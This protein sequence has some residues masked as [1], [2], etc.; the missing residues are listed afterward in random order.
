M[1][2][3]ELWQTLNAALQA[4]PLQRIE[5][6]TMP[7]A[8]TLQD[9]FLFKEYETAVALTNHID[10]LRDKL[11]SFF[12][13]FTGLAGAAISFLILD[14]NRNT[15]D[16]AS[17]PIFNSLAEPIIATL[18][19]V[20]FIGIVI[21]AIM[22]KLRAVQLEHFRIISNIRVY[23]FKSNYELWNV[24]QLS[25]KTLPKPRLWSGTYFWFLTIALISSAL[26]GAAAFFSIRVSAWRDGTPYMVGAVFFLVLLATHWLYFYTAT[27][28]PPQTYS[29]TN[30]PL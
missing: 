6:V 13:T 8:K 24:V 5:K 28:P 21:I 30:P 9:E 22:G 18:S 19:I 1:T 15:T 11:S 26:F 14:S 25:A 23:F 29:E 10:E 3:S 16:Q 12:M 20:G 2:L 27:P 4:K 7:P 17:H